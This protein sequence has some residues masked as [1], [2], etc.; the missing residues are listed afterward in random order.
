MK[1]LK[2]ECAKCGREYQYSLGLFTCTDCNSLGFT[3]LLLRDP[4]GMLLEKDESEHR[5]TPCYKIPG[6]NRALGIP[7]L[8]IKDETFNRFGT[9][10]DRRSDV[11]VRLAQ[12][13]GFSKIFC[14]TG[15]NLGNSL[16]EFAGKV[17]I[18]CVALA[19]KDIPKKILEKLEKR[20][21]LTKV[22]TLFDPSQVWTAERVVENFPD[23]LDGTANNPC[24]TRAYT[25]IAAE[26][27]ELN[28][29]LIVVP[30]GSGELFCG[31]C[32]GIEETGMRAKVI[33]VS[34]CDKNPVGLALRHGI[35][36]VALEGTF[37][38]RAAN[39][40]A[41]HFTPL[42]P[43]IMHFISK[44]HMFAE[45][46]DRQMQ[47]AIFEYQPYF[48][49]A[50][51]PSS[52]SVFAALEKLPLQEKGKKIVCVLTGRNHTSEPLGHR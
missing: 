22:E 3:N 34:V 13:H 42:M 37:E 36:E 18:G 23:S 17:G 31:I 30:L 44:G 41:V 5:K 51:E 21:T 25:K 29:E 33:G 2:L 45:I 43:I 8:Y 12:H 52:L 39:K 20:A 1:G 10:K 28:P 40:I 38:E 9:M 4:E 32:Q 16:A 11:L 46:S 26:L 24:S 48:E 15:G 7:E 47:D 49:Q 27:S 14:V 50:I 35:D 6:L 19:P